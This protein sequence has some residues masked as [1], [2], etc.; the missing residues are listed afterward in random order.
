MLV[1]KLAALV[2]AL[3]HYAGGYMGYAYGAAD[4]VNVLAACTAGAVGVY[5]QVVHIYLN[6]VG[7][8]VEYRRN[9]KRGKACVPPSGGVK[10][11][12]PYQPV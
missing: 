6:V 2:L 7:V 1:L 3:H 10:G 9:V 11:R 8:V 4:L 12:Y 5:A